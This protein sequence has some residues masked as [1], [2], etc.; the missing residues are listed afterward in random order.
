MPDFVKLLSDEVNPTWLWENQGAAVVAR[1]STGCCLLQAPAGTGDNLRVRKKAAPVRYRIDAKLR[2]LLGGDLNFAGLCW[3]E[4][5]TRR[6][7]VVGMYLSGVAPGGFLGISVDKYT[8]PDLFSANA[9]AMGNSS[10][11]PSFHM[12][13]EDDGVNRRAYFSV[14]GGL[15]L[16]SLGVVDLWLDQSNWERIYSEDR[17]TFMTADEVGVFACA[18]NATYPCGVLVESWIEREYPG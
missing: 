15:R 1:L 9:A 18:Y 13:L 5:G 10:L 11:G 3:R 6:L 4:S 16:N 14:D 2:V 17:T 7:V 12:R 8:R